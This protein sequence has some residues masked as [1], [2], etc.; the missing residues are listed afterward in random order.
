MLGASM[1]ARHRIARLLALAPLLPVLLTAPARGLRAER[2]RAG[3][4]R[5]DRIHG[6]AAPLLSLRRPRGRRLQAGER[7]RRRGGR[8]APRRPVQA[9]HVADRRHRH[10]GR[11]LRGRARQPCRWRSA[12]SRRAAPP[13]LRAR[14]RLQHRRERP[15]SDPLVHAVLLARWTVRPGR[16]VPLE[17]PAHPRPHL[18]HRLPDPAR[19]LVDG[20]HA[21]QVRSREAV[22]AR[23]EPREPA[24]GGGRGSRGR[25]RPGEARSRV[26]GA[27]RR[28]VPRSARRHTGRGHR[29]P[30][31]EDPP[32]PGARGQHGCRLSGGTRLSGG[33]SRLPRGARPRLLPRRER[34]RRGAGSRARAARRDAGSRPRR[35]RSC[36]TR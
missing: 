1:V 28:A 17:L 24:A 22:R 13:R 26:A 4:G 2:A 16:H 8:S 14:H 3:R 36:S 20:S 9:A 21:P 25:P 29:S 18:H 34:R 33:D 5:R 7:R 19:R 27:L 23:G 15:G 6:A 30:A 12:R 31:R 10:R 35:A 11:G 32:L